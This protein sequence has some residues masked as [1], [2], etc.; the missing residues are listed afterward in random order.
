MLNFFR[1]RRRKKWLAQPEPAEW[2]RWLQANVWQYRHLSRQHRVK[3]LRVVCILFHEKAWVG[4]SDLEVT[5]EMRVTIAGQAALATLGFE[6]PF[7]FERLKTIIVYPSTF[8][9]RPASG[10]DLILGELGQP[11]PHAGART[12]EAW[13]G[14]PI[15]LSWEA[16]F[17]EGK[18]LRAGRNVVLHEFAHHMDGLDGATDGAPP[19]TDYS[20]EKKWYRV[21]VAE[22]RKLIAFARRGEQTLLDHYGATSQ[23]EF[24]A[25]AVECFFTQ[26]HDFASQHTELFSVLVRLFGQDPRDWLPRTANVAS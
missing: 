1:D 2:G 7:Y 18:H 26:P 8:T 13:Q 12:G 19:M 6:K 11:I 5:D 4:G 16:V 20:F 24:F 17:R 3:V 21:T 23:A 10:G 22:Y 25:V 14:G 15:I 9:G